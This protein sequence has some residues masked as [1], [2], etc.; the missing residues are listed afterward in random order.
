MF[1]LAA[2]EYPSLIAA[3]LL[4]VGVIGKAVHWG[5]RWAQRIDES[6]EYVRE[7]LSYNGG[8]TM[9]DAVKRI[10]NR[11]GVIEGNQANVAAELHN[12]RRRP[13][14]AVTS[15]AQDVST[16][17]DHDAERDARDEHVKS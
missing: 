9:R 6:L 4:A 16:L 17:L 3:V 8:A 14:P 7:E 11:L 12:Y 13:D 10:E 15:V 2:W 5:Y 1:A